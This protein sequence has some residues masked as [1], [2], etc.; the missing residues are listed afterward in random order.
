MEPVLQ[1]IFNVLVLMFTLANFILLIL[2]AVKLFSDLSKK[3]S[4]MKTADA[5]EGP[6]KNDDDNP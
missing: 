4:N 6:G 3:Q 1:M 2:I 5:H